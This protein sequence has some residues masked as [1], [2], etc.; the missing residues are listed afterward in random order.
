VDQEEEEE[1]T[2]RLSLAHGLVALAHLDKALL[3]GLGSIP[4]QLGQ[5]AAEV[6]VPQGLVYLQ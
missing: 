4:S 3:A 5:L 2:N 1:Q 6:E